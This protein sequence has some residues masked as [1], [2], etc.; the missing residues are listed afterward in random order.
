LNDIS[1]LLELFRAAS[2]LILAVKE[3]NDTTDIAS[4]SPMYLSTSFT[5]AAFT[6]LRMMKSRFIHSVDESVK[7]EGKS[8]LFMAILTLRQ[9]SLVNNDVYAKSAEMLSI[10]WRNPAFFKSSNPSSFWTLRIRNRLTMSVV[11]DTVSIWIEDYGYCNAGA[12]PPVQPSSGDRSQRRVW[13]AVEPV[14][15]PS[16]T[17]SAAEEPAVL[18]SI[19]GSAETNDALALPSDDR[20]LYELDWNASLDV[21]LT[22]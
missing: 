14:C 3:L 22:E 19:V 5:L 21:L 4:Y 12:A 20:W 6:L 7:Q 2:G 10:M 9:I 15:T 11:F 17:D 18:Q 16:G 13:N 1:S 8:R